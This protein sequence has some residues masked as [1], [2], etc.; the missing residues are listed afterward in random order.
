M[1]DTP[2]L[3]KPIELGNTR[4]D[5]RFADGC[6]ID[7]GKISIAGRQI[8][9]TET[10]FLPWID[11]F[12]GDVFRQFKL[13]DIDQSHERITLHLTAKSDHDVLF[14]EKRDSSGDVMMRKAS[15][16]APP[17][18][19]N[20]RIVIDSTSEVIDGRD[21]HGFRYYFEYDGSTPIHRFIN[22][23]TW[24]LDGHINA[25]NLCLRNWIHKPLTQLSKDAHF[26]PVHPLMRNALHTRAI[27]GRDGRY[28][29]HSIC[30]IAMTACWL[31]GLTM[32][33]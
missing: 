16:D 12:D 17:L 27:S 6:L 8:R 33:P 26:Q 20:L 11:T 18:T 10:R 28:Y 22:R 24:E 5:L 3:I 19:A 9:S 31:R 14:R 13:N 25:L 32:F 30:N 7:I 21:F 23:Q 4:F 15:W 29:H 2:H 1:N